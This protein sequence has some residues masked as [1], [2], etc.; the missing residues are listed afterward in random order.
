MP[1]LRTFLAT[2]TKK[3]TPG[4]MISG[5]QTTSLSLRTY[6]LRHISSKSCRRRAAGSAGK[7]LQAHRKVV[8]NELSLKVL[9]LTFGTGFASG[10]LA[11]S[12]KA[13][14]RMIFL[15][16]APP[17]Q[18]RTFSTTSG[19]RR[20]RTCASLHLASKA[21]SFDPNSTSMRRCG[22]WHRSQPRSRLQCP[23]E[24]K[25]QGEQRT[26][27]PLH[28]ALMLKS[29]QRRPSQ[30][31]GRGVISTASGISTSTKVRSTL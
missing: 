27:C 11:Q 28:F 24:K 1:H 18:V 12:L 9:M 15:A 8:P 17:I 26:G 14:N 29:A 25:R 3:D 13:K 10:K 16:L 23:R 20:F 5:G 2:G 7:Y 4:L 30:L 19:H 21:R 22:A 31:E 6:A